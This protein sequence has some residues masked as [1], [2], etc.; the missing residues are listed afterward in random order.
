MDIFLI[1]INRRFPY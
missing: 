1:T